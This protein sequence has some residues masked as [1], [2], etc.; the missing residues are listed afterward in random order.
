MRQLL[1][2]LQFQP[3]G[4]NQFKYYRNDILCLEST[5]NSPRI[6]GISRLI[7]FY[8]KFFYIPPESIRNPRNSPGIPGIHLDFLESRE[9]DWNMWGTVKHCNCPTNS[10]TQRKDCTW[11]Y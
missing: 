6:S 2:Q 1:H 7:F 3:D 10:S 5:Q 4:P 9:S 8:L 11:L